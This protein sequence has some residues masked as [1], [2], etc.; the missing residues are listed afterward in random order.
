ML[1]GSSMETLEQISW[2]MIWID[3]GTELGLFKLPNVNR[4]GIIFKP[5]NRKVR[6]FGHSIC[7]AI[8]VIMDFSHILVKK[9]RKIWL[10]RIIWQKIECFDQIN[11]SIKSVSTK[12]SLFEVNCIKERRLLTPQPF[13]FHYLDHTI[14][15]NSFFTTLLNIS[16]KLQILY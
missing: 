9:V 4:F 5:Y 6:S 14:K 15:M 10:W 16:M 12:E 13:K 3:V 8:V 2:D 1:M 11:V 7:T